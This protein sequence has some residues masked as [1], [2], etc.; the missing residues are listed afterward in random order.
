MPLEREKIL[1]DNL[2]ACLNLYQRSLVW[3]MTA[4]FAFF[5]LTLRLRDQSQPKVPMLYTEIN[6]TTA[7]CL[8]LALFFVFGGFAL[9]ALHR[10]EAILT[11][12]NP[13]TELREAIL[14]YPSLATNQNILVRVGSVLL[15]PMALVTGIVIE[16]RHGFTRE[17]RS[18]KNQ[19]W[20]TWAGYLI[21]SLIIIGV[22]GE[23]ARQVWQPFGSR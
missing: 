4:S 8:A 18:W 3:A 5:L 22:Y 16:L 9:S 15:C 21:L 20:E 7:W 1:V 6:L 23:L 11:K 10:A 17:E 14:L 19:P 13:P 2:L 12:L